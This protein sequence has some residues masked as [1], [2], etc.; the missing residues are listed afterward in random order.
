VVSTPFGVIILKLSD[1]R[2]TINLD[3]RLNMPLYQQ[4][5]E[6]LT[7]MIYNRQLF[8]DEELPHPELL[9]ESLKID[10]L[11]VRMAYEKLIEENLTRFDT[12]YYVTHHDFVYPFYGQ[13]L[14]IEVAL[15]NQGYEAKLKYHPSVIMTQGDLKMTGIDFT[16]SDIHEKRIDYYAG[17]YLFAVTYN[18]MP[19]DIIPDFDA[20]MKEHLSLAEALKE[21][22]ESV[23]PV[24]TY[25]AETYPKD[26][27]SAFK[28]PKG[29]AGMKICYL[30][31]DDKNVLIHAY[32]GYFTS[33]MDVQ[34]FHD[35]QTLKST[36]PP[37][38]KDPH[39]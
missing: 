11:S 30:Y 31:Y 39:P 9:A 3:E 14:P 34:F 35:P 26:V 22:T 25:Q 28:V 18:Y 16:F 21:R 38:E 17:N 29:R 32:R 10:A 5:A 36:A 7:R 2:R 24:A 27:A 37:T 20:Y 1:F 19:V 33:W 4:I 23:K 8:L 12:Q 15:K 6:S 13:R